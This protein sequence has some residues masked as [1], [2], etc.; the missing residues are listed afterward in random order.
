MVAFLETEVDRMSNRLFY[1]I[2]LFFST[3]KINEGPFDP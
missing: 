2:D 3:V 1:D